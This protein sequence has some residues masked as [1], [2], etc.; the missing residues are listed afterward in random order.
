MELI[1][2]RLRT[3][4]TDNFLFGQ[5]EGDLL[6]DDSLIEKGIIDSTGV[7]QL[8]AF[9]EQEFKLQVEDHEVIPQNLDSLSRLVAFVERKAGTVGEEGVLSAHERALPACSLITCAVKEG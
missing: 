1:Q 7:L 5:D 9:L 8:I 3:F 2:Q 6:A 4:V